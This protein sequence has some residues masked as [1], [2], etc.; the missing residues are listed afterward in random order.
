MSFFALCLWIE[1]WI[2]IQIKKKVQRDLA[3]AGDSKLHSHNLSNF[4]IHPDSV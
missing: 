3:L 4:Q 1:T 2:L